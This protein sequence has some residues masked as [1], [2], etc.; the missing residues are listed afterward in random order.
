M[1]LRDGQPGDAF[2]CV[3]E[4]TWDRDRW[5]IWKLLDGDDLAYARA[6]G[7][8]CRL[9]ASLVIAGDDLN[10]AHSMRDT[11]DDSPKYLEDPDTCPHLRDVHMIPLASIPREV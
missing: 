8:K 5:V 4:D 2:L 9:V 11:D 7:Y 6:L 1:R 10:P 3:G